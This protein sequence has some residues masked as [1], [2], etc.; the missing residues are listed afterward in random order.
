[1]AFQSNDFIFDGVSCSAFGLMLY[2]SVDSWSQKNVTVLSRSIVTDTVPFSYRP[3]FYG[4][5]L[6]TV[7]EFPL[8]IAAT[9][10]RVNE[11]RFIDRNEQQII[12]DWLMGSDEYKELYILQEDLADIYYNA[13]VTSMDP[14]VVGSNVWG[15]QCTFTCDSPFGYHRSST[16]TY[17]VTA[18]EALEFSIWNDSNVIKYYY[19]ILHLEIPGGGTFTLTNKTDDETRSFCIKDFSAGFAD[20]VTID[21]DSCVITSDQGVNVYPYI[22]KFNYVRMLK[23]RNTFVASW[24]GDEDLKFSLECTFPALVGA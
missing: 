22:E 1:L 16:H 3:F 9:P 5:T 17:T 21:N 14:I 11:G 15:Y 6:E 13:I 12:G 7:L 10:E 8:V 24:T 19:P 18:D 4:T 2:D 20:T 23:G